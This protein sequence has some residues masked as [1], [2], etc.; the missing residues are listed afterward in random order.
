MSDGSRLNSLS[1]I[2]LVSK[3][4]GLVVF[5]LGDARSS[6]DVG[7][8]N[9]DIE[10]NGGIFDATPKIV[11]ASPNVKTLSTARV[12]VK[13]LTGKDDAPSKIE[14]SVYRERSRSST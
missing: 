6:F 13:G 4:T 8:K 12:F 1:V 14:K 5:T 10:P 11:R 9:V 7:V 3:S 2:V